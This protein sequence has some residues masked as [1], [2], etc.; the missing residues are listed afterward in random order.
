M[1]APA[2]LRVARSV[3]YFAI[4]RGSLLPPTRLGLGAAWY[5][6]DFRNRRAS[7]TCPPFCC[8]VSSTELSLSP[9][10]I[11]CA[12]ATDHGGKDAG[13]AAIGGPRAE[14]LSIIK[15]ITNPETGKTCNQRQIDRAAFVQLL[16]IKRDIQTAAM[17]GRT[18]LLAGVLCAPLHAPILQVV[19]KSGPARTL[20]SS[21]HSI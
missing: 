15:C 8:L 18:S 10:I 9:S 21:S 6:A 5:R 3:S 13:F 14:T 20:A 4:K 12:G 1:M 17:A 16:I 7:L 2:Q 11:H 19:G